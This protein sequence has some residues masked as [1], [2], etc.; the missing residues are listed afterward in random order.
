MHGTQGNE[1][2]Q[3]ITGLWLV[4]SGGLGGADGSCA[5]AVDASCGVSIVVDNILCPDPHHPLVLEDKAR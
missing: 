2:M 4:R 5:T 1:A 3:N